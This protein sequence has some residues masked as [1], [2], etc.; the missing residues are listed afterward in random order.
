MKRI[1]QRYLSSD[2]RVQISMSPIRNEIK[3]FELSSRS[4]TRLGFSSWLKPGKT[5]IFQEVKFQ[6]DTSHVS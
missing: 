3:N 2:I 4:K 1:I 6:F 5:K